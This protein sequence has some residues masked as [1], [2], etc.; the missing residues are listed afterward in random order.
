VFDPYGE[1][2][3]CG[4]L[5]FRICTQK[6]KKTVCRFA[7]NTSFMDL[8]DDNSQKIGMKTYRLDKKAVDP[9]HI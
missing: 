6:S 2:K 3:F 9:D 7:L 8:L 5:F 1:A 4:D